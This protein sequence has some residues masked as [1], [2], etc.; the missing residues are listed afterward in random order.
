[1]ILSDT[2]ILQHLQSSDITIEPFN[3]EHL[4]PAS[5]TFSLANTLFTLKHDGEIDT[6]TSHLQY[7][8]VFI[9]EEGFVLQP[10]QFVLGQIAEELSI[11]QKLTC[12]WNGRTTLSRIGLQVLQGAVF[13]EPGQ[14]NSHE[15]LEI[16][17]INH[18][19]IRL[20]AGMK[21]VKGVFM[22]L[23]TPASRSYADIGDYASQQEAVVHLGE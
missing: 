20:Y 12:M 4:N 22:L 10:G 6:R 11:T 16:C 7:Q 8:K 15:V 21:I 18:H 2:D 1:M 23:H 9:P 14:R 17:N 5:Y 3:K 13:T 19:P